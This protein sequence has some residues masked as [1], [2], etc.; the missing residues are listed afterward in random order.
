MDGWMVDRSQLHLIRVIDDE[1]LIHHF[2]K[3]SEVTGLWEAVCRENSL[4]RFEVLPLLY[5]ELPQ[6]TKKHQHM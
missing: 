4:P 6:E 1:Y 2:M 3:L 5:S